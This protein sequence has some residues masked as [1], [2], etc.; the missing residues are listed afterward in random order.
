L[1]S[2]AGGE[3]QSIGIVMEA[4]RSLAHRCCYITEDFATAASQ[5]GMTQ[6]MCHTG[7][8]FHNC[9]LVNDESNQQFYDL[10]MF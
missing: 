8:F 4:V 10:V 7:I 2:F 9:F 5:N 3:G 6:Q 1:P